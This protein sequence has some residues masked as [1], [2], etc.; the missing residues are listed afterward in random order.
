MRIFLLRFTV[1]KVLKQQHAG[2]LALLDPVQYS[3]PPIWASTSVF[4]TEH[5]VSICSMTDKF[6]WEL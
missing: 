2:G 4:P 3:D 5:R 6:Y 1:F